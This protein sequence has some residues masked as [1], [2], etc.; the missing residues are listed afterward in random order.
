VIFLI[1]SLRITELGTSLVVCVESLGRVQLF[2]TPWI[3]AHQALLS[4]GTLQG[5]QD[6]IA[7]PSSRGSSQPRD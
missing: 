6:W 1:D 7:K 2:A 5:T 4:M 3:E